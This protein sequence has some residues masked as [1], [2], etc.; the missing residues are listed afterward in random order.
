MLVKVLRS[1]FLLYLFRKVLYLS[2]PPIL[3]YY[4]GGSGLNP[5]LMGS[6]VAAPIVTAVG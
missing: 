6:S 2:I 4:E 5:M 1:G 3:G